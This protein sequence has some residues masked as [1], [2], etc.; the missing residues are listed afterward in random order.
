MKTPLIELER[1]SRTFDSSQ[2]L[3]PVNLRVMPGDYL[4]ICGASGSG[5]STMLN[6][7][8][9]LDQPTTGDVF[10]NGQAVNNLPD[11]RR[12]RLRGR[13]IGFVFQAFHLLPGRTAIENVDLGMMYRGIPLTERAVR[14]REALHRVGLDHRLD[15]FPSTLSGGEQQRVAIARA[16]AADV[17]VLLADEPTGNLDSS[18]GGAILD[19]FDQLHADGLSL[20]VVTHSD[21]VAHRAGRLAVMTDGFLTEIS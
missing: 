15:A 4:A 6:I 17:D 7:L 18:T 19:L 14:S 9:L 16:L 20:V 5:K 13:T 2:I 1:V 8:G 12:A 21:E 3:A 11:S 10:V